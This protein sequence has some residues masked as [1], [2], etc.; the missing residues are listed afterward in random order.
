MARTEAKA[1]DL[2]AE[3]EKIRAVKYPDI[4]AELIKAIVSAQFEN[5]DD[6]EKAS[7]ATKNLID[8]YLREAEKKAYKGKRGV[9]LC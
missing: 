8:A 4:P 6:R 9:K 1:D 7:G 2:L 5:E 3:L